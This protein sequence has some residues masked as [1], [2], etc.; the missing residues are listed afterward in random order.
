MTFVFTS[1]KEIKKMLKEELKKELENH[2][3]ARY[4]M[5]LDIIE[6][7]EREFHGKLMTNPKIIEFGGSNGFIKTVFD[8]PSYEIAEN[9]PEV[10]ICNLE[11][12]KSESYDFVILDQILEHVSRPGK[13]LKEIRR[14]LKKGGWLIITTPFLVKIHLNPDDY[15]RFSKKG[16]RILLSE[17]SEV[18]LKS[19]GNKETVIHHIKTGEWHSTKETRGLGLFNINNDEE[20]PHVI[21]GYAR[22]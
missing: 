13:A 1:L 21:W 16:L 17:F 14:I 11:D 20:Y 6:F 8:C 5:Y 19:W 15:W 22:K 12:Y 7:V 18:D 3:F 2:Q 9:F 10:D 4:V